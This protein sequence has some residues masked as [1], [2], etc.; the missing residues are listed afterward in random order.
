MLYG[1]YISGLGA[2]GYSSKLEV[3]AN[4]I[5]NVNSAGF[6]PSQISFQERLVEALEK[7]GN[8]RHYNSLVH[9]YGGAPF[10]GEQT[11]SKNQGAIESTG[12]PLDLAIDGEGFFAVRDLN[13]GRTYYTRA[14]NFMTDEQ[15]RLL[16]HDRKYGVLNAAGDILTIDPEGTFQ[17][18]VGSEG[19]LYQGSEEIAQLSVV[20]GEMR[21]FQDNLFESI[22][23]EVPPATAFK[24]IQGSLEA[25]SANPI[26][27]MTE[28]LQTLRVIESNLNM[29]RMQDGTLDRLINDVGRPVR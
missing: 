25:S 9:R 24:I 26:Y 15:G 10:I 14:G 17:I 3:I 5:A 12:R 19:M 6:R 29:V 22:A 18:N 1:L 20:N 13:T 4:N 2:F 7:P 28:M 16:T 27:E 21:K 23:P 8:F 11:V